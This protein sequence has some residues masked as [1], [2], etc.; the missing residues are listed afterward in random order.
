MTLIR[1]CE[2]GGSGALELSTDIR[3]CRAGRRR[4]YADRM[5]TRASAR[6]DAFPNGWWAQP[7]IQ[8]KTD[9][10]RFPR[11][12]RAD[13]E[14]Q[15]RVEGGRSPTLERL[16]PRGGKGLPRRRPLDPLPALYRT[17]RM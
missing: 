6:T 7:T 17:L 4:R 1:R 5:G 9:F 12:R 8:P 2:G 10:S 3:R 16:S 13:F 15:Q 11:V 14:V